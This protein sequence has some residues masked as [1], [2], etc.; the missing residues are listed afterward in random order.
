MMGGCERDKETTRRARKVNRK[1]LQVDRT[2]AT[3]VGEAGQFTSGAI[4]DTG[5]TAIH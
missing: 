3:G 5:N 2:R 4:L 1:T